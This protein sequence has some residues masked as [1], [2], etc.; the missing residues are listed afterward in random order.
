MARQEV[1]CTKTGV[2]DNKTARYY[3]RGDTDF[4]EPLDPVAQYFEGWAPGTEV[5]HKT[6]GTK[7]KDPVIGTRIVPGKPPLTEEEQATAQ[8]ERDERELNRLL[9]EKREREAQGFDEAA[10]PFRCEHCDFETAHE[11]AFKRHMTMEHPGI[12]VEVEEE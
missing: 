1:R 5:Y 4:I 6:R 9:T 11:S 3:R 2:F 10:D 7:D 8:S 12:E